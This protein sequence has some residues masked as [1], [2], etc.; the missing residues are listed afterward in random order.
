MVLSTV[1]R[2]AFT[3]DGAGVLLF[4]DGE[5]FQ[6]SKPLALSVCSERPFS[7]AGWSEADSAVI[8]E[9]LDAGALLAPQA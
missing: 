8:E 6:S 3:E 9:L 4:V 1:S 2:A 5:T 7:P